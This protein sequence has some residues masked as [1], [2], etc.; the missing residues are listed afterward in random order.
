MLSENTIDKI[1]LDSLSARASKWVCVCVCVHV[2]SLYRGGNAAAR[3]KENWCDC[4]SRV[5]SP[6]EYY[7]DGSS[8]VQCSILKTNRVIML[9]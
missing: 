5:A 7:G 2:L 8:E 9:I 3:K 1:D 6:L 4:M